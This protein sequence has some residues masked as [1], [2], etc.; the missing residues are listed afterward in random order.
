MVFEDLP[1]QCQSII[2]ITVVQL[3]YFI[4]T[5]LCLIIFLSIPDLILFFI[6]LIHNQLLKNVQHTRT[7]QIRWIRVIYNVLNTARTFDEH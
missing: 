2:H 6:F 1:F 7:A 3:S 5:A 4:T